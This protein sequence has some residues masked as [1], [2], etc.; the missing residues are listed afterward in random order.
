[1]CEVRTV[2]LHS[3]PDCAVVRSAFSHSESQSG[4]SCPVIGL[5]FSQSYLTSL[6]SWLAILGRKACFYFC[7]F[8]LV[9]YD[10]NEFLEY[11]VLVKKEVY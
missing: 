1:M 4:L 10:F 11:R 7:V 2:G 5:Q 3:R 9:L 6:V 8:N